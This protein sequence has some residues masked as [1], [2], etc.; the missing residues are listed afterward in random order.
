VTIADTDDESF[1][2]SKWNG[3]A[4]LYD[5]DSITSSGSF[6]IGFKYQSQQLD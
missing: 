5:W 4:Y 6:E 1:K 3:Q 2:R